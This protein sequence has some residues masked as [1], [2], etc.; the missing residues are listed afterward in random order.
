MSYRNEG[1]DKYTSAQIQ[2]WIDSVQQSLQVNIDHN[3][4]KDRDEFLQKLRQQ[5]DDL[6][7]D[8]ILKKQ[9]EAKAEMKQLL[10]RLLQLVD[11]T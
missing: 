3:R 8:L 7:A 5:L 11:S 9:E 1:C 4:N 6:R 2:S 10:S